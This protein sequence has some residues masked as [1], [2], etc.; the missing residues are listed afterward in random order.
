MGPAT[1]VVR[2]I[3]SQ[4]LSCDAKKAMPSRNNRNINTDECKTYTS[5]NPAIFKIGGRGRGLD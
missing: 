1:D 4:I 2:K 5:Y 3:A